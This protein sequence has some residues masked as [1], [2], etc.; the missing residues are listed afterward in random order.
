[1]EVH[2]NTCLVGFFSLNCLDFNPFF[3]PLS[4][5]FSFL[6]ITEAGGVQTAWGPFGMFLLQENPEGCDPEG[7]VLSSSPCLVLE[8]HS[9]EALH[10]A[11]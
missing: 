9:R 8:V 1:M 10:C 4:S 6:L 3:P 2:W 11:T 7:C 5:D